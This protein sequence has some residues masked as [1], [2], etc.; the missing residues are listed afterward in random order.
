MSGL[1]EAVGKLSSGY[2]KSAVDEFFARARSAYE[3]AHADGVIIDARAVREV[4]FPIARGGYSM[5]AVD[6]ALDRL[7]SAFIQRERAEHIARLGRQSWLDSVADRA[8]T[9][10]PRLLRPMGERF[11]HP[12]RG[13]GYRA[14]EVDEMCNRLI[15]YFDE[16]RPLASAD[17]RYA[18]FPSARGK[19]AY[20]E[21]PVDAFFARAVEV[22]LAVE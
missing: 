18:I 8:K 20:A 7:E 14:A 17:L 5:Q 21:G 19:S 11:A 13:R 16:G 3:G 4:T 1:F 12:K 9:L 15:G 6:E 22:L 2:G 10:Y